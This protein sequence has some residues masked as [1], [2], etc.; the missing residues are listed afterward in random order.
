MTSA[1]ARFPLAV[2]AGAAGLASRAINWGVA[3]FLRSPMAS[4]GL[5]LVSGLT[6]LAATNALFLQEGRHPAPLF[7]AASQPAAIETPRPIQPVVVEPEA[8][9]Q[10]PAAEPVVERTSTAPQPEPR[11]AESAEIAAEPAAPATIG[12]QAI[13]DMQEK[14]QALGLFDGVVDGYYGPKTADAIRAFEARFGLPRTGAATPQV[15]EAVRN[16]PLQPQPQAQV[17]PVAAEPA[18]DEIGPLIA[19][20]QQEATPVP[21]EPVSTERQTIADISADLPASNTVAPEPAEPSVPAVLNSDLVSDIQRGLTRLGFLQGPV[22]GVADE[23]TARAI[24]QFQI[25]NNYRPTGEVSATL[26]QM[27]VEAGAYL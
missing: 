25:F 13:A 24:R 16:A 23:A 18:V 15:I 7:G 14:L 5:I 17:Q 1:I 2:G 9:P 20:M 19:Q 26:R 12:N 22:N 27:L 10:R 11:P 21:T 6:L 8:I 4:T 3:H